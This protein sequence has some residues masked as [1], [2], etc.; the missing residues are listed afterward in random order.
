MVALD[1]FN[2]EYYLQNNPDI[3]KLVEQGLVDAK[4]HFELFGRFES[5]EFSPIFNMAEY[6]KANPDVAQAV[7]Q[8]IGSAL[9]H[10]LTY[11]IAEPRDLGNGINI[12]DFNQDDVFSKAIA[13]GNLE[14]AFQRVGEIAPF[15]PDFIAPTGWESYSSPAIALPNFVMPA[16]LGADVISMVESLQ[17]KIIS[18]GV[19][20][21]SQLNPDGSGLNDPSELVD[22]V[23]DHF[24][25]GAGGNAIGVIGG[26]P[27]GTD[28]LIGQGI[29]A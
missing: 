5:R 26:L 27:G 23:I 10:L 11:G 29:P 13:A 21:P 14:L 12:T 24:Y 18:S 3:A 9:D 2:Y 22:L 8:G 15:M 7:E 16:W 20:D 19:I 6:L 28:F 4:A 17:Q 25:P 1:F